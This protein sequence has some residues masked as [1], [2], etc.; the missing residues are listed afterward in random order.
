MKDGRKRSER[1]TVETEKMVEEQM[2]K[3]KREA[4][5]GEIIN[6]GKGK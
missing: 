6:K 4:R 1:E 2:C 3:G 5:K